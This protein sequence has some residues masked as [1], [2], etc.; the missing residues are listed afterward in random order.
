MNEE[1]MRSKYAD[2]RS[3]LP[4]LFV[5][6]P[7]APIEILS[8]PADVEAAE[9]AAADELGR[10]GL[11]EQWSRT[12]VVYQDPFT[13]VV[14]DP[15]RLPSGR[16]GTYARTINVGNAPGVVVLP[17]QGA[18]LLLIRHFRHSTRDWHLEAP[19]GFGEPGAGPEAD[20]R[21]EL[22]EEIG[23][24]PT[25]L[26]DLGTIFPDTGQSGTPVRLYLAEVSDGGHATDADEGIES[27]FRY[28]AAEVGKMI[29]DET[30]TD[31]FTI[32]AYARAL[33]RGLLA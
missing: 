23:L 3:A 12:G 26:H 19:R 25:S 27:V 5:N 20:A 22:E 10:R 17:R 15:V 8:E 14:R 18:D 30:I 32:N 21:R 31:G 24:T 11:P 2:L 13:T 6:P 1:Q 4:G 33:I 9:R 28:S 16:L 29:G 7:G